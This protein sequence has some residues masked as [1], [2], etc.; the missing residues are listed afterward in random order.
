MKPVDFLHMTANIAHAAPPNPGPMP[1]AA[2]AAQAREH[3]QNTYQFKLYHSTDLSLKKILIAAVDELYLRAIQ[4][5]Q[6]GFANV[7]TSTILTHL[8]D[9]Y[10]EII[11]KDIDNNLVTMATP[12]QPTSP[13]GTL[14]MTVSHSL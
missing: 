10:G 3:E 4:H 11:D 7:T 13:I 12:W 8:W 1:I 5:P 2:T 14:S 9:T 6:Q